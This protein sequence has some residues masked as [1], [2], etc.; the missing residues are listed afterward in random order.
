MFHASA[1]ADAVACTIAELG[2][3][4]IDNMPAALRALPQDQVPLRAFDT[5][6]LSTCGV[7]AVN[8]QLGAGH[9]FGFV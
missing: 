3:Q 2:Q 8:D 9:K 1:K 4:A 7:S 5:V 6:E